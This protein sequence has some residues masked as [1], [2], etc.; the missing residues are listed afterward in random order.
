MQVGIAKAGITLQP[1]DPLSLCAAD[2]VGIGVKNLNPIMGIGAGAVHFLCFFVSQPYSLLLSE[3]LV[4]RV[5]SYVCFGVILLHMTVQ[6]FF[7]D[8]LLF[9]EISLDRTCSFRA[10]WAP[11][12]AECRLDAPRPRRTRSVQ[13]A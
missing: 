10:Q 8:R 1:I 4:G 6:L 11:A 9:C 13:T 3:S 7:V 2:R 12:P 5:L